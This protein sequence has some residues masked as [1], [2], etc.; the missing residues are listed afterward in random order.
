MCSEGVEQ[1]A[2]LREADGIIIVHEY[3]LPGANMA[4]INGRG[5]FALVP[6]RIKHVK[7]PQHRGI[8]PPTNPGQRPQAPSPQWR[9]EQLY[10]Y[11]E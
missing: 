1:V 6:H 10:R 8:A 7:G 2:Q 4:T 11:G 9:A 3:N 5:M